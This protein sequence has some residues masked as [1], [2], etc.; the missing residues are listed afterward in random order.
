MKKRTILV[1]S[2]AVL[3]LLA[4]GC[5]K[6][7]LLNSQ[8]SIAQ[9]DATLCQMNYS[10]DGNT[11]SVILHGDGELELLLRQL[12]AIS[13]EGHRVIIAG[14]ATSA[15]PVGTK[16][17]LTFTTTNE[18]EMIAWEKARVREGYTVEVVYDSK[19]GRYTGTAVR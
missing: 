6:E 17:I 5:Q 4:A 7:T 18:D 2:L 3:G 9:S 12:N 8:S 14:N 15:N 13:R 1:A 19:T 16:E 10:V 11:Y